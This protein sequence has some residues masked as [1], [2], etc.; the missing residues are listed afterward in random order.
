MNAISGACSTYGGVEVYTGFWWVN[1]REKGHL[2]DPDL[3]AK[4][5]LKW[6]CRK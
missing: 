6:I 4:V 1:L 5:T 2:E 3:D